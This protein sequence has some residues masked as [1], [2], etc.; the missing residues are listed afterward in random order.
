MPH[1]TLQNRSSRDLRRYLGICVSCGCGIRL[2]IS[3]LSIGTNDAITW[4]AIAESVAQVGF[5]ETY[6][7]PAM[8]HPPIPVLWSCLALALGGA[9]WFSV[10]FKLP[11]ILADMLACW[12]VAAAGAADHD[13]GRTKLAIAAI[14]FNP[15]AILI[16]AYH[17]NTDSIYACLSLLSAY[18]IVSRKNFFL[19]GLALGAAINVK[20]I[21]VLLIPAA[22]SFCT[23]P[24]QARALLLS[25]ILCAL[26]FVPLF[27]RVPEDIRRNMLSYVARPDRWGLL[28]ALYDTAA[29]PR[30]GETAIRIMQGYFV[31]GR[32]LILLAAAGIAIFSF[33]RARWNAYEACLIVY[34]IFLILAPGFS[35]QYTVMVV[36]LLAIVNPGRAW[37]Y[38]TFCGVFLGLAYVMTL[39]GGIPLL[40]MFKV[41]GIPMPAPW[42]GLVA[43]LILIWTVVQLLLP[44]R[45]RSPVTQ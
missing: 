28:L 32:V 7:S 38:A 42:F 30:F 43:W 20:L 6:K 22:F 9:T 16:S 5:F 12:L 17:G 39:V 2:L 23:Q 21:P 19:A 26:P 4:K 14:A 45:P 35:V 10:V 36:P 41:D 24:R 34:S 33:R 27:I 40:S 18:F 29:S 11:M 13:I 37:M 31:V 8:N 15:V 25:L 1:T 44:Q 3:A